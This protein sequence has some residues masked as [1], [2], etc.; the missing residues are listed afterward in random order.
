MKWGT[1]PALSSLPDLLVF[2][3]PNLPLG[4]VLLEPFPA[5]DPLEEEFD[6]LLLK[7]RGPDLLS[8]VSKL[9]EILLF[10][11]LGHILEFFIRKIIFLELDE[12]ELIPPCLGILPFL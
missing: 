7:T 9:G 5:L 3:V 12:Y 6:N 2:V 8:I 1:F 11:L 4:L 10:S